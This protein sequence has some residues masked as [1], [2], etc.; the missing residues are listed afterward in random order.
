M[1]DY[2]ILYDNMLEE[3]KA[4]NKIIITKDDFLVRKESLDHFFKENPNME[5]LKNELPALNDNMFSWSYTESSG[6]DFPMGEFHFLSVEGLFA[7]QIQLSSTI[8]SDYKKETLLELF[9]FDDHPDAGD[10]M[11]GCLRSSGSSHQIW[12]HNEN[13]EALLT[14]LNLKEY[15]IKSFE[16]KAILGWQYLFVELDWSSPL[17]S[18]VKSELLKRLGILE[19]IFP[20]VSKDYRSKLERV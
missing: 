6:N 20:N 8:E 1:E 4:V 13:S 11:M 10:G 12:F 19:S 17:Y 16:L 9:P 2:S 15:L 5:P 14:H 3:M 7:R 18:V